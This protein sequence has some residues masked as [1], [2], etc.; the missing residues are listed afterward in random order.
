MTWLTVCQCVISHSYLQFIL[1]DVSM[2][3]PMSK[4]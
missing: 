2:L 1:S 4:L 3:S